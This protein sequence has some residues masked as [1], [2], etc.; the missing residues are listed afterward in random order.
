MMTR[1]QRLGER[2]VKRILHEEELKRLEEDSKKLDQNE[3]RLSAN[4]RVE[5]NHV[6]IA[7]AFDER[8]K[9]STEEYE[10]L[11]RELVQNL[12][13]VG[14]IRDVDISQIRDLLRR[15]ANPNGLESSPHRTT[16]NTPIGR[17]AK[18]PRC[19]AVLLEYGVDIS[20]DMKVYSPEGQITALG[21]AAQNLDPQAVKMLLLAGA[22][23]NDPEQGIS[24]IRAFLTSP[25]LGF[26]FSQT[27]DNSQTA[28]YCI[29][30]LSLLAAYGANVNETGGKWF[31]ALQFVCSV[32]ETHVT[33]Y[34]IKLVVEQLLDYGAEPN[35]RGGLRG[36]AIHAAVTVLNFD[37]VQLLL[38]RGA[39]P[40][41]RV[42]CTF[43]GR[44]KPLHRSSERREMVTP[45]EL[46]DKPWFAYSKGS[47]SRILKTHKI[48]TLL[49]EA[50]QPRPECQ[51]S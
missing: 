50:T 37:T 19:L 40:G 13:D 1:E 10:S 41:L 5:V 44:S 30:I 15:G 34:S 38:Q 18:S 25:M 7:K 20:V 12:G 47:R 42:A 31:T 11:T 26:V 23:V 32:P 24:P 8:S 6:A 17:A 2:E 21:V 51:A 28:D 48:R 45:S 9:L 46:L 33:A 43:T 49:E 16:Q 4:N 39:Y 22:N 27:T 14:Q 36:S 3:A 35:I 29:E